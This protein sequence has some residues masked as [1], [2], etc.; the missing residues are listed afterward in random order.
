[1]GGGAVNLG[2]GAATG[3]NTGGVDCASGAGFFVGGS[4][5]DVGPWGASLGIGTLRA[6]N[7]LKTFHKFSIIIEFRRMEGTPCAKKTYQVP[8]LEI[9]EH[10]DVSFLCQLLLLVQ[11]SP[12]PIN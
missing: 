6:C 7:A 3:F 4:G 1:M 5:I 9:I 10:V 8:E 11:P 12:K 2:F